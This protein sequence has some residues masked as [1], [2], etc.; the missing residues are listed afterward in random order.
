[1]KFDS[2]CYNNLLQNKNIEQCTISFR[3]HAC[4]FHKLQF[5]NK[6]KNQENVT[7]LIEIII[8]KYCLN[9]RENYKFQLG[10]LIIKCLIQGNQ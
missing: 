5:R 3:K 1:M 7:R 8:C 2:D 4:P 6:K 9:R 10:E